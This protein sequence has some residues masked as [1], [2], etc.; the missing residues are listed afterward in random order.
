MQAWLNL[1]GLS[2]TEDSIK[3]RVEECFREARDI[4]GEVIALGIKKGEFR[5]V[6]PRVVANVI[7]GS[8]EGVTLL[9][10]IDPEVDGRVDPRGRQDDPPERCADR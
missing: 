6:N 1:Y 2:R 5:K 3:T 4:V 9:W 10:V 7:L 8:L